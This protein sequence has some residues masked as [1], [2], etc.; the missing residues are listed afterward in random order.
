MNN[1]FGFLIIDKP[2]GCSSH[3]CVHKVRK[4]FGIKRVG[5]GGTLDP[6]VTGVL[7]LAVGQATRLF[8]YLPSD[9]QY[10]GIIQLGKCTTSDDLQGEIISTQ[11][12]PTLDLISLEKHLDQFRGYIKQYPPKI[13]SVHVNGERAYKRARK[14]ESFDLP[15]RAVSIH[16]LR[17]IKWNQDSGQIHVFVHC[18]SGTYIRSLARDLGNRLGCGGCLAKLRRTQALGFEE[19]QALQLPRTDTELLAIKANLLSPLQALDHLPRL[20]LSNDKE[21]INWR[22]GR[23]LKVSRNRI[24]L[25]NQSDIALKEQDDNFIV[26]TTTTEEVIG[27]GSWISSSELKPKVVFNAL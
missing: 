19:K 7:P 4:I 26:I 11:P 2:S 23:K 21:L 15:E 1:P 18:S 13:S 12:W 8:P 10:R 14:G 16:K 27:I 5:H 17:L 9:K 20:Q 22:T 3:D 6:S 25:S 24:G